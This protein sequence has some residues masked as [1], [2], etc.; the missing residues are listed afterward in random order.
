MSANGNDRP[1]TV[2]EYMEFLN[3]CRELSN[4]FQTHPDYAFMKVNLHWAPGKPQPNTKPQVQ[5]TKAKDIAKQANKSKSCTQT[6][7]QSIPF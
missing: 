3:T 2:L 1:E 5:V 6:I 7:Q 4:E